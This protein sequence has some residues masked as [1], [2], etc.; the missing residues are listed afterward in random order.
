MYEFSIRLLSSPGLPGALG[1]ERSLASLF[2]YIL[3]LDKK[4]SG[5]GCLFCFFTSESW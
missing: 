2:F 3:M 4:D 1:L 5:V